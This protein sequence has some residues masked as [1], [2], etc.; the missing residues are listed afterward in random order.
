MNLMSNWRRDLFL[1]KLLADEIRRNDI[2]FV[3]GI[4]FSF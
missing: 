4:I 2:E 1:V 3:I